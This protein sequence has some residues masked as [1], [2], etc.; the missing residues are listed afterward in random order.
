MAAN[1][2]TAKNVP[3]FRD[4][5]VRPY[6]GNTYLYLNGRAV[7][8]VWSPLPYR[9]VEEREHDEARNRLAAQLAASGEVVEAA[10]AV[11]DEFIGANEPNLQVLAEA[12]AKAQGA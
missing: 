7:G 6:R 4:I 11:L 12:V 1:D 2:S 9:D 3:A 5:R 8:E 10:I